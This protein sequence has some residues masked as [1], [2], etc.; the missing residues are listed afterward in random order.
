MLML[1]FFEEPNFNLSRFSCEGI[2]ITFI[3]GTEPLPTNLTKKNHITSL[4]VECFI[5]YVH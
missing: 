2:T 4:W 1:V 5:H 3:Q